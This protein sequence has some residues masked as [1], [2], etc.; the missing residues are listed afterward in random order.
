MKNKEKWAEQPA[1]I[2]SAIAHEIM[3]RV[4][5]KHEKEEKQEYTKRKT[6]E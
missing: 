4:N 1:E 6:Q 3:L 2:V 5:R